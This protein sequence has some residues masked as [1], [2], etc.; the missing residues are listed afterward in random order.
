M[1]SNRLPLPRYAPAVS[2]LVAMGEDFWVKA[3]GSAREGYALWY[4]VDPVEG[5]VIASVRIPEGETVL[6]GNR[7]A[8]VLLVRTSL[9]EELVLVRDLERRVEGEGS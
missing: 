5:T 8:V 7:E 9:D 4:V 6:S 1:Y 2:D 3:Y